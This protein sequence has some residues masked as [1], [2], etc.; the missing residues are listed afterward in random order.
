MTDDARDLIDE[1]LALLLERYG[2]RAIASWDA[3]AVAGRAIGTAGRSRGRDRGRPVPLRLVAVAAALALA[4]VVGALIA[5][6]RQRSPIGDVFAVPRSVAWSPD[7]GLAAFSVEVA[8]PRAGTTDGAT[9]PWHTELW[10]VDAGG[11]ESRRLAVLPSMEAP[12]GL[13]WLPDGSGLAFAL[14]GGDGGAGSV[15][16]VDRAGGEPRTIVRTTPGA[17]RLLAVTP[18]A[19][20]VV[21]EVLDGSH[22]AIWSATTATGEA[23]L[24]ARD[25]W[26]GGLSPD[27]TRLVYDTGDVDAADGGLTSVV[28]VDGSNARALA[29]CCALGWSA[30]GRSVYVGP[31]DGYVSEFPADGGD[32]TG[33]VRLEAGSITGWIPAP[34]AP[35]R[36]L[37]ATNVGLL[38]V[39]PDGSRTRLTSFGG[40]GAASWSPDGAWVTF[41]GVRDGTVGRFLVQATGGEPVPLGDAPADPATPGTVAWRPGTGHAAELAWIRGRSIV[42]VGAGGARGADLLSAASVAGLPD[43]APEPG[44]RIVLGATGPDAGAYAVPAGGLLTIENDTDSRWTPWNLVEKDGECRLVTGT[45]GGCSVQPHST[46][47]YLVRDPLPGTTLEVRLERDAAGSAGAS[48]ADWQTGIP[49]FVDVVEASR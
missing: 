2:D 43:P 12:A 21:Y 49:V 32:G 42:T 29:Q 23:V 30:D 33:V 45:P 8:D 34:D 47:S 17:T 16:V 41:T 6:G 14:P 4:A 25:A 35:G 36:A 20:R 11:G 22:R 28:G 31:G 27:G 38:I 46:V 48:P 26:F 5:A 44:S 1:R 3:A 15:E 18:D 40:D 13:T 7:G 24:V 19:T 39:G 9:R 37:A 10:V